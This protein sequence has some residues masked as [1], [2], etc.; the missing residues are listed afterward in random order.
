[1]S[2]KRIAVVFSGSQNKVN[3]YAT[4]LVRFQNKLSNACFHIDLQEDGN[5]EVFVAD[6]AIEIMDL[7]NAVL[8]QKDVVSVDFHE[9]LSSNGELSK[10]EKA[11]AIVREFPFRTS[12]EMAAKINPSIISADSLH[13]RLS[14]LAKK[15]RVRKVET[16]G[17][18]ITGKMA[19]TWA[20]VE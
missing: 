11:L 9:A 20:P 3:Q 10:T 19:T 7:E 5:V 17:C 14:D 16:R 12:Q 8:T 1:M 6:P 15:N 13:K 18:T 4:G 2:Q